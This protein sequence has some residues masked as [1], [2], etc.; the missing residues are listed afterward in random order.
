MDVDYPGCPLRLY[1]FSTN[2]VKHMKKYTIECEGVPEYHIVSHVWDQPT[3]A[4]FYEYNASGPRSFDIPGADWKV[5]FSSPDKWDAIRNFCRQRDV[6]WLWMDVLCVRQCA[7]D[8]PDQLREIA[9]VEK[10]REM[11]NMGTY[12]RHAKACIVVPAAGRK[13]MEK[14]RSLEVIY[15]MITMHEPDL[16]TR[17]DK[18]WDGAKLLVGALADSYFWQA[19]TFQALVL[20]KQCF[21][22]DGTELDLDKLHLL[23]KWYPGRLDSLAQFRPGKFNRQEIETAKAYVEDLGMQW[24]IRDDLRVNGHVNILKLLTYTA[25]RESKYHIDLL[26]SLFGLLKDVEKVRIDPRAMV[27]PLVFQGADSKISRDIWRSILKKAVVSGDMWPLL[28]DFIDP[29]LNFGDK[30][31]SGLHLETFSTVNINSGGIFHVG[32][33]VN[34]DVR[35]VGTVVDASD[36]FQGMN[37]SNDVLRMVSKIYECST[38]G[39]DCGP[40]VRQLVLAAKDDPDAQGRPFLVNFECE[41][42]INAAF[43]ECSAEVCNMHLTSKVMVDRI[44]RGGKASGGITSGNHRVIVIQPEGEEYSQAFVAIAWIN[45]YE[46]VKGASVFDVTTEPIENVKRWVVANEVRSGMV[47]KI[48]SVAACAVTWSVSSKRVNIQYS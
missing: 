37:T 4:A 46:E 20:S 28:N 25:R 31:H 21:F 2:S 8:A 5:Q 43:T 11:E 45:P 14:Y 19:W 36:D 17:A 42:V 41:H 35:L 6:R 1:D 38:W 18:L 29:P 3:Q 22:T 47:Q 16:A 40:A 10:A 24:S 27:L 15:D 39:F 26:F 12:Y 44:F 34:L 7:D 48:G 32:P 33:G 13:T 23:V 9:A 30:P